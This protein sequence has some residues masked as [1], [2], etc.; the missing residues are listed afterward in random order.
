MT[1][2]TVLPLIIQAIAPIIMVILPVLAGLIYKEI[3]TFC[4]IGNDSAT[5]ARVQTGVNS[6]SDIALAYLQKAVTAGGPVS[7]S[8]AVAD[9]LKTASPQ[10]IEATIRGG[11]SPESLSARVTGSLITK[12]NAAPAVPAANS[13]GTVVGQ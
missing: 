10:L 3:V 2:S 7:V 11:T 5:A 6:L 13:G 8:G 9:A 1:A 12:A 4:H